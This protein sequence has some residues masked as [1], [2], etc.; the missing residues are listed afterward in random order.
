MEL[1]WDILR[2]LGL[3]KKKTPKSPA[4]KRKPKAK[5]SDDPLLEKKRAIEKQ[6][7]AALARAIKR[8]MRDK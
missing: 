7:P 1:L 2:E 5:P 3:L 6:D 4:P 8:M